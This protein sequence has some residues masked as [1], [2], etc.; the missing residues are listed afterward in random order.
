MWK[1]SARDLTDAKALALQLLMEEGNRSFDA[2]SKI[3]E[4]F[5]PLYTPEGQL[6]D[7]DY[8]AEYVMSQKNP[9][10]K[11]MSCGS[12]SAKKCRQL[13]HV[14]ES[15]RDRGFSK[16]RAAKQAWGAVGGRE[17]NAKK[18]PS[19]K[20]NAFMEPEYYK[21]L[22]YDVENTHGESTLVPADLIGGR[23]D[24]EFTPPDLSDFEDYIEGKP[25]RFER[26][27]GWFVR[28]SASGYMDATEWSGPFKTKAEARKFVEDHYEVD[29]D[30]GD[31]LEYEENRSHNPKED[32]FI[33]FDVYLGRKNI[34]TVFY[35]KSSKVTADEVRRA[36]IQHDG[37]DPG[38]TVKKRRAKRKNNPGTNTSIKQLKSFLSR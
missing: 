15:A 26:V 35:S 32:Y 2:A 38:I 31:E 4:D 11:H 22:F 16:K 12:L 5:E 7:Y 37:Y 34:D 36:L 13:Q 10:G 27:K 24:V 20:K 17:Y 29:P 30:T 25:E 14:Y 18:K 33:A 3:M 9:R 21:G 19:R 6:G 8:A 28:L 23:A 1:I